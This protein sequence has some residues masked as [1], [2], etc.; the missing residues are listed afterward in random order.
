LDAD[1]TVRDLKGA[2]V[3]VVLAAQGEA[4][5]KRLAEVIWFD[6]GPWVAGLGLLFLP[7]DVDDRC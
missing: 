3:A 7:G 4:F 2:T 6:A 1:P 5:V